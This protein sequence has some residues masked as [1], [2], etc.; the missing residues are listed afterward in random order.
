MRLSF[1]TLA[2]VTGAFALLSSTMAK[3]P[4]LPLFA[5]HLGAGPAAIG[6]VA[7]AS[8]VPG[9][10]ASVPAGLMRDRLG[11]GPLLLAALFIFATAPFL[12]L[13]V[14]NVDQ[15]ALI[16]FY[17]GFATAIFGT[18]IV[19]E[20]AEYYP[21]ARGHAL[22]TYSA[23]STI[24]RSLAPFLGGLLISA[25][26]FTG[27]YLGCAAAG[28]VA[29][30]VGIRMNPLLSPAPARPPA[31][32]GALHGVLKDRIILLTSLI[33]A[34]QFLV[35]G[36]VEVFLAVYTARAGWAAWRIGVL[37]GLQLLIVVLAKPR[38]GRLS[39]QLGR[40][41]VIRAGLTSGA[42]SLALLPFTHRFAP[43]LAINI[44]F[45]IGFAATTAATSALVGDRSRAGG[46]GA[47][48]GVLRSIMD[49]GQ[50]TGPVLTGALV[51]IGG[52]RLAF[53]GLAG[54]LVVA[55]IVF[56]GFAAET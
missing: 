8:T 22:A 52:F 42:V 47:S 29:L 40:R 37:L 41:L 51:E 16:R 36:A 48:I 43:L 54:L 55:L 27:V 14:L 10:L 50:A 56:Q 12:Y 3:T 28:V 25:T 34:L 45:G 33:E 15:L 23:V 18:A 13:L 17:H 24:G 2:G 26:G 31:A 20:I 44:L 35:F 49:I 9:I 6:A 5:R 39:D 21:A 30:I 19:A 46:F 11:S 4:A 32:R 53:P 1:L 38:L 7:M